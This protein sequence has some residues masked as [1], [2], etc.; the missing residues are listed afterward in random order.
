[1]SKAD[2]EALIRTCCY[3]LLF[4]SVLLTFFFFKKKKGD[5]EATLS[6]GTSNMSVATPSRP[7]QAGPDSNSTFYCLHQV[8]IFSLV[9]K[10]QMMLFVRLQKLDG[11]WALDDLFVPLFGDQIKSHPNKEKITDLVDIAKSNTGNFLFLT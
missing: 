1:M 11:L 4:I 5:E 7:L 10:G 3:S 6:A 2:I 8:C 9:F